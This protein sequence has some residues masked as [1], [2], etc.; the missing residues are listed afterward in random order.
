[1]IHPLLE[2]LQSDDWE[3]I[4]HEEWIEDFVRLNLC[5]KLNSLTS[6][7]VLYH[8]LGGCEEYRVYE[9][10]YCLDREETLMIINQKPRHRDEPLHHPWQSPLLCRR[11][12]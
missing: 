9:M 8:E 2:Y 11:I 1:M 3:V 7:H 10:I 5:R 12:R 4:S 6:H